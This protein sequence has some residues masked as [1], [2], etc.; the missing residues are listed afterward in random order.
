MAA[1]HTH[2]VD[3][4]GVDGLQSD[5]GGFLFMSSPVSLQSAERQQLARFVRVPAVSRDSQNCIM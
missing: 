4:A 1:T 5:V 2:D 3:G